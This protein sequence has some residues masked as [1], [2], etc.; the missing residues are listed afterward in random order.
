M[1][2]MFDRTPTLPSPREAAGR[3]GPRCVSNA[4]R[5]GGYFS[6]FDREFFPP[7]PTPPRHSRG[8][9]GGGEMRGR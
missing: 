3:V 6:I 1:S 2:E 8:L 5:G 9:V 7:P 4:S